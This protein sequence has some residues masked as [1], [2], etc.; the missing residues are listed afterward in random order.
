MKKPILALILALAMMLSLCACGGKAESEATNAPE[1]TQPAVS[2]ETKASAPSE[3]EAPATDYEVTDLL[4]R[5]VTI[6]AAAESF[7]CIGPG[8][9]RL[10]TYVADPAQLAGVEAAEFTSWGTSGR[11][12][13]MAIEEI[14]ADLPNIG[15]WWPRQCTGC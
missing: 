14:A 5:T 15:P 9:L 8:C 13:A 4:G 6:P 11:P 1:T 12:Y 2:A 7:A 10:Y 3:T